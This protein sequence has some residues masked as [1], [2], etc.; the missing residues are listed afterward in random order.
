MQVTGTVE[1]RTQDNGRQVR[2]RGVLQVGV[3]LLDDRVSAVGLVRGDDVEDGLLGG[4]EE[5]V[6]PPGVEQTV[7]ARGAVLLGVE[8]GDPADDEPPR[9]LVCLLLGG[10]G[11]PSP[12]GL[13]EDRGVRSS[14]RACGWW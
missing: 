2:E 7:L 1:T 4:G 10:G 11:D 13:I 9:D 8:F 3:D 14:V 6:E 12:G 5:R